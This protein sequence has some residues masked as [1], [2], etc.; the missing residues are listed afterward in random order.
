M[1]ESQRES[2]CRQGR[3][4]WM[5][6]RVNARAQCCFGI[7]HFHFRI[8]AIATMATDKQHIKQGGNAGNTEKNKIKWENAALGMKVNTCLYV[9]GI[10]KMHMVL[11]Q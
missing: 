11:G 5:R 1:R 2:E 8:V 3:N 10:H 4:W 7:L 6:W 9:H